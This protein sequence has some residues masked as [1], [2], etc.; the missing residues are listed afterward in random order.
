MQRAVSLMGSHSI[1][2]LPGVRLKFDRL[3]KGPK[4]TCWAACT[5]HLGPRSRPT[6]HSKQQNQWNPDTYSKGY[7][8]A[9]Y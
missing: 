3:P 5:S 6:E 4:A 9:L 7:R 8:V 1:G 2:M